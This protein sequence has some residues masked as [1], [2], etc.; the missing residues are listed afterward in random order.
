MQCM[1][2]V[3]MN[4]SIFNPNGPTISCLGLRETGA[5]EEVEVFYRWFHFL[6]GEDYCL[7]YVS[8][9]EE[10]FAEDLVDILNHAFAL[11][12]GEE[13]RRFALA[14]C[15]PSVVVP[16]VEEAWV[17]ILKATLLG[18]R[19]IQEANW[20]RERYLLGK[21][22]YHF[23]ERAGEEAREAYENMLAN[24]SEAS[25]TGDQYSKL[26]HLKHQ[27]IP[28]FRDWRPGQ[29]QSRRLADGDMDA[30]WETVT[31]EDF[32]PVAVLQLAQAWVGA[33]AQSRLEARTSL[34][35]V[36]DFFLHFGSPLWPE[37]VTTSGVSASMGLSARG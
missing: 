12:V 19:A 31:G 25:E 23:F 8:R 28:S 21:Y 32:W 29:Y 1:G 10:E 4:W 16:Y 37:T 26:I 33:T 24:E 27:N 15:I 5:G 9:R 22:G 17:P 30:W 14:T 3:L 18:S 2:Q 6:G 7:G 34:E 13:L 35:E 36:R 20:G 11:E